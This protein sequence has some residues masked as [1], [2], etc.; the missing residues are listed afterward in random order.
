M[1]DRTPP[2]FEPLD[3]AF[4]DNPYPFYHHLREVAPVVKV[5]QGYWLLSRYDDVAL[6]LRD[7]RRFCKDFAGDM[8]RR[9]GADR[10]D[11][12]AIANISLPCW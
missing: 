4:I 8:M 1:N 10:F 11:E 3:P 9:Y 6:V 7:H 5:A 2:D 12:P